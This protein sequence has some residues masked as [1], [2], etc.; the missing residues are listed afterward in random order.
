MRCPPGCRTR[1]PRVSVRVPPIPD[2][3]DGQHKAALHG[4]SQLVKAYACRFR[5][6]PDPDINSCS[7]PVGVGYR[8]CREDDS[9]SAMSTPTG[10]ENSAGRDR[11]HQAAPGAGNLMAM[12]LQ[13][14]PGPAQPGGGLITWSRGDQDEGG[15]P[16]L[17]LSVQLIHVRKVQPDHIDRVPSI[18]RVDQEAGPFSGTHGAEPLG[19]DV[20]ITE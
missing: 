9:R 16:L 17:Q 5:T 7:D 14:L 8:H 15:D 20:G 19:D 4:E 1:V 10:M 2:C 11:S 18:S 3:P 6:L 12:D 13:E